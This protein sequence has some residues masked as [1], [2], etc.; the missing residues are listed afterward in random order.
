VPAGWEALQLPVFRPAIICGQHSLEIFCLG[1]F[2]SFAGHFTFIQVSDGL[3]M[4]IAVSALGIALMVATAALIDWY[5]KVEGR[6]GDP[7]ART[8]DADLAGG[9]VTKN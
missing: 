9:E 3:L 5:K 1:I 8:P 7:R 4:Q 2:L 6:S